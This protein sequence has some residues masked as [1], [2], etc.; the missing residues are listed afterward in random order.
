[1]QIISKGSEITDSGIVL[2]DGMN[3]IEFT[4]NESPK[5]ILKIHIDICNENK[6]I[7][8]TPTANNELTVVIPSNPTLFNLGTKEPL[9]IGT[10]NN[11]NLRFAF[12]VT[13]FGNPPTSYEIKYSFYKEV[14]K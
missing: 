13:T 8:L 3:D 7:T 2:S 12:R 6:P 11:F 14:A 5:Q 10:S 9:T 4:L 1:M